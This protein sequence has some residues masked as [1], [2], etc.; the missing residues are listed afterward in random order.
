MTNSYEKLDFEKLGLENLFKNSEASAEYTILHFLA[1]DGLSFCGKYIT[2]A[3]TADK[4]IDLMAL[5]NSLSFDESIEILRKTMANGV[6]IKANNF[7]S[8]FGNNVYEARAVILASL[9]FHLE[10]GEKKSSG[11][12]V[13][14]T[15]K[16]EA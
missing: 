6:L 14:S 10:N 3:R 2:K 11:T 12:K 8:I 13:N 15:E 7:D 4:E 1:R 5:V 16:T 9:I